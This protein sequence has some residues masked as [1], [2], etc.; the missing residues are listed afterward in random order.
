MLPAVARGA[1]YN[2]YEQGASVLGMG[3][4]GTASVHDASAVYYNPAALTRLPGTQLYGGGTL[5]QPFTS[6]AGLAP[7]PGY[8]VTEKMKPQQFYPPTFYFARRFGEQA[9]LGLGLNSPFGLGV[10]WEN[11][12]QFTG[13][14]IV[15]KAD[16]RTIHTGLSLA[17]AINPKW[18]VALGG[19]L[20]YAKVAL[21]NRKFTAAPGG[22]G[23]ALEVAKVALDSDYTP[24]YGW[25]L[26]FTFVP[27]P[28]W[29]VGGFYR[30][31]FVVHT[32]GRADLTQ[33]MTGNPTID[34]A[35]AASLPP[36]QNVSTVLRFPAI[37]S[38]GVA[39]KWGE[40]WTFE[41][42][43]NFVEWSVFTD[44][45]I[46]FEQSP[47]SNETIVENYDDTWQFRFG[48]ERRAGAFTYRGGYYYDQ[49]AA[50][51]PS[52]SPILPDA[53]RNGG[54]LGL[55]YAFG[56]ERR[57]TID[58]YEL[59]LFLQHRHTY[60][61]N[62]DGFDGHYRSYVNASGLSLAYRW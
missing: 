18:S 41:G 39:W 15:T 27:N 49:P 51:D 54:T 8:G 50:P 55:G 44:L 58:V 32:D 62:R 1:G 40:A 46:F 47:S 19:N 34:A 24:G 29:S 5:L 11:P 23:A 2:I 37:S 33:M 38:L 36:D 57:W 12:D 59:A 20:M 3:G 56:K 52:L 26:A 35:V 13:R 16:L 31:K 25:N 6:F 48:M 43:A 9:A 14:Y 61:V 28:S 42:D 17:Y 10:E 22:G 21:Q 53:G 60:L 30:S 7:Y 4:A 45:P